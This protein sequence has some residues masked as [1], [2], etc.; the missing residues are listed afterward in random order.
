[1]KSFP[2][3]RV[4][5]SVLLLA[6]LG[7]GVGIWALGSDYGRRLVAQKVRFALTH[8]SELV[9]EPFKVVMSPWSDFPYLT[10]S[11]QHL[12]LTDTAYQQRVPV[13]RIVRADLRLELLS[14]LRGQ[15]RVTRL[16]VTDVDF[17]ERVDSL[18]HTWGLRGKRRKGTGPV[19]ALQLELDEV[20]VH[21]FRMSSRNHYSRSAFGAEV[22]E[23]RLS[24]RLRGGVLQVAGTLD[25]ELSYLR[26]K[27]GT[28]FEQAPVRAWVH[29]KY[30]FKDRQ[31]LIWSTRATLN[32]DTI[33]VSG[34]HHVDPA[35]P[36]GTMMNLKFVGNQP[37]TEVL[38]AALPPRL[39]PYLAG[40]T[41]P[42]KAHIHYT[43]TGLSGPTV[44]P[45]NVLTF[46]LRG[47]SLAWPDS[48]RRINRWDLQGTYDN[49]PAHNTKSTV[50]TLRR[51]RIYSS[52]GQL[53]VALTLRDFT[54]PYL[55]GRFRGRTEL[56]ELAA[57]VSPGRWRA[58]HGIADLDVQLRGLLPPLPGRG[59]PNQP[60]KSLSMRGNVT[61]RHASFV[62]PVRGAD[63]S[64]LNVQIGLRD[65]LCQLSNAS[66]VLNDMRFRASAT[67]TYLLDYLTGLHST[68]SIS[69]DFAVDELRVARLRSL[70]RPVP[71]TAGPGFSPGSLPKPSR[72][73]RDKAQLAAT[74]GSDLIPPGLMLDVNLRCQRLLLATDTLSNLAV[75]VR[76]D[77]HQ[78]QLLNL[79]G[80]VW[81]GTVHGTVQWP[82]DPDN[83]V[84][85]VQYQLGVHF[86]TIN[87]REFMARLARPEPQ[88]ARPARA[89]TKGAGVAIP[90]LRDLLLTANGQVT[91]DIDHVQLPETESLDQ[92]SLQLEKT[93]PVM[94]MPYLH[95]RT[96]EGG[97]GEASATA[98][99]ENM[100]LLAADA[101]VTLRYATLD[102]Q[103]LLAMIAS[104]TTPTDSVPT[105]RT[106]ART[107]RRAT[108]RAERRQSTVSRSMI[109]NGVLSAVL[110]VEA[111]QVHYGVIRGSRFRLVSHLLD[112]EARLDNL[113]MDALG[114]HIGLSGHMISTANR[115]HHP[116]QAQ[117]RLDDVALPAFFTMATALGLKVLSG[118]N[119]RGTLRGV[120]DLRTDLDASFLPAL[121][122]TTG[123][124]KT[125][126][127]NLE[128]LD[129]EALVEALKFMKSARTS[130]LYF[131]PVSSEFALSQGQLL[132][133]GL[134]LN[135][136]LSNL[137]ISGTY[138]LD[139][140]TNLFIGLKPLQALFG[141]NDKRVERIQNGEPV[142]RS[143]G[144][145]TYVN[146][147]RAGAGEKYKVR[148]F[149]KDEQRQEQASL[150]Q[151]YRDLLLTQRLDTTV[152]LLR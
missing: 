23:A 1:M 103:R 113:S 9:L 2:L 136:N 16:E 149:Q 119:I 38:R 14:L 65:S 71:R 29:Y 91:I 110:H 51:C 67:T 60:Q 143:T 40:A 13:L 15:V 144:K 18:G 138:G 81:G 10:A 80:G 42:S 19:P 56:P 6:V 105:A 63:I 70:M 69:G 112:G 100:H 22:H 82:T 50:L 122:Q 20:L 98:Q 108:R 27:A 94:H 83:R 31:G 147:R 141:N 39:D 131:E 74:L 116:T 3:R 89:R 146:L 99:V 107:E 139:G 45:R 77:G 32:G 95:F 142:S 43:I 150:R 106:L 73:P 132:I 25:G 57:V 59:D 151:Q 88:A 90:A 62:L 52:A 5:A 37:L 48:A 64:D 85:P 87:Y 92:V 26:T 41:S 8:N 97:Q 134:S 137:E 125:D 140:R 17:R 54:R 33:R 79:A 101:D 104:L 152:R 28:L 96:P 44:S 111:D 127:R 93:G 84:A 128:L 130:H 55:N 124:L 117:L 145:L 133:P 7:V 148:L 129:V 35:Q 121:K 118:D 36:V 114:G 61:L 47:A 75:T 49:G 135:S 78:V 53:D 21:N 66:G 115:R 12:A 109:S 11:I 4:L 30:T 34:T 86:A 46:G 72:A 120:M 123:Y 102:V 24:A 68:A 126:L 76:H 58:R